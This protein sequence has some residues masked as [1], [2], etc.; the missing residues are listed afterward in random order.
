M[1]K[2]LFVFL[3]GLFLS[4]LLL[5]FFLQIYNPF[6]FTITKGDNVFFRAN[7]K[8]IYNHDINSSFS[9]EVTVSTILRQP[10]C[11]ANWQS[12]WASERTPVEVSACT[13]ARIFASG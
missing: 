7:D 13:K 3:F 8:T 11:L 6:Q 9:E 1:V 10:Y 4:F 5:E 2:N 12:C